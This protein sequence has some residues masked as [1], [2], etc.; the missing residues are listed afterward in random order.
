MQLCYHPVAVVQYTFTNKQYTE[1]HNRHKQNIEQ[2]NSLIRKCAD[3]APSLRG[4]RLHL[5]Y[6]WGKSTENLSLSLLL[7]LLLLSLLFSTYALQPSRLIVRSGL[8]IPT[9]ATRRLHAC[10]HATTPSGRRWNCGGEM[11][12]K[13]CLNSDF[14]V[15]CRKTTAWNRRLYFPSEGR[16]AEDF[17]RPKIPTASAGCKPANLGTKNQHATSRPLKPLSLSLTK[18]INENRVMTRTASRD[19]VCGVGNQRSHFRPDCK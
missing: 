14:H 8:D 18:L 12:G 9:F 3:R 6:N 13:F 17:F 15:T 1:R 5:P 10:H 2:N 7:L 4:I 11:S 19:E 16:R